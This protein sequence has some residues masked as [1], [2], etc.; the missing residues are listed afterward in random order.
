MRR[1]Q[2]PTDVQNMSDANKSSGQI[3]THEN[4]YSEYY[5]DA[6]GHTIL[7]DGGGHSPKG[8][9]TVE[10]EPAAPNT[11]HKMIHYTGPTAQTATAVAPDA[12]SEPM[13]TLSTCC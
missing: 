1:H 12:L 10:Y 5:G 7:E 13:G 2:T 8:Y 11:T 3:G 6:Y 9:A 4:T